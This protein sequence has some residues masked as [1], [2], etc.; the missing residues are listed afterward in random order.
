MGELTTAVAYSTDSA[1][2]HPLHTL[3]VKL[4]AIHDAGFTQVEVGFPDLE[5]FAGQECNEG[6][7]KLN[8]A[9]RGD[10]DKLCKVAKQVRGLCDELGMEILVVHP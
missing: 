9:G 7:Q 3:P 4:R 5:A 8:D 6:Y 1:G 10:V 2:M